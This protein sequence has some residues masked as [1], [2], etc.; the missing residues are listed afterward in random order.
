MLHQSSTVIMGAW[1]CWLSLLLGWVGLLL[2]TITL[3]LQK[4]K[5][6]TL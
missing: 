3:C 5:E 1:S 4:H 2:S 6:H